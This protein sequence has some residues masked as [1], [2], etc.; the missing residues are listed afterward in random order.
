MILAYAVAVLLWLSLIIYAALEGADFGGGVWDLLAFGSQKDAMRNLIKNAIG[1]VW[2]ANNV[3]LTY[4]IVGLMTAFPFVA[5][6]LT[7]AFFI[8]LVL[9]LIGIVLRGAAFV[10]RTFSANTK[11]V[12]AAWGRIFS[13]SSTFT[14]F[15]FGAMA[16]AVASGQVRIVNGQPPV[17][18]V[19]V[20]LT[21]FAIVVGLMGIALSA[22]IA[23][24][25]LTVEAQGQGDTAMTEAFR[26]RGLISGGVMAALGTVGIALS[27]WEAPILWNG[28]IAHAIWAVV[29]T[30]LLGLT[31]A[32][33]LFYRRYRLS[34]IL[35][36]FETGALLG[37]WGLAQI[38]YIIP[39]DLTISNTAS[40]PTTLTELF[41]SALIGM[42]MLI[43]SFWF[44][45]HIF[46]GALV[47]PPIREAEV[48]E[49][50]ERS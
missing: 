5:Q 40:P 34:R 1:A 36:I 12:S 27:P 17:G 31:V 13:I 23:A 22:T 50:G 21:P 38:P 44:L 35:M 32:G 2:E 28:M 18:L 33:A 29:I 20:W 16:A 4:L 41:I 25:Y 15:L 48:R 3:W 37:T 6:T 43:P 30:V 49:E 8:P 42:S 9:I 14:P 45:F 11:L 47:M 7:T 46:K 10:F 19:S 39:P 26:I 24:T